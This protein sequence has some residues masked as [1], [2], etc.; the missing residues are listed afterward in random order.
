MNASAMVDAVEWRSADAQTAAVSTGRTN[1][2]A[3]TGSTGDDHHFLASEGAR[4]AFNLSF[5]LGVPHR[6]GIDVKAQAVREVLVGWIHCV[7]DACV[8]AHPVHTHH[9]RNDAKPA[10]HLQVGLMPSELLVPQTGDI[11][12][13]TVVGQHDVEAP[14]LPP[15][16]AVAQ[17]DAATLEPV[18]L[19]AGGASTRP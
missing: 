1:P 19:G 16:L 14:D 3:S 5:R 6:A 15:A 8:V 4:T 7:A 12:L 2:G 9:R 18:H 11:D 17:V 13:L 10:K